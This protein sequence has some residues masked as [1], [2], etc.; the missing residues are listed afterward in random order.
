MTN[1]AME[2][3]VHRNRSFS[4]LEISIY[5]WGFSIAMLD[6]QMVCFA[7]FCMYDFRVVQISDSTALKLCTLGQVGV[8]HDSVTQRVIQE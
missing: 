8:Q 5:G 4:Q 2:A 7:T 1:M 3:M 6:N